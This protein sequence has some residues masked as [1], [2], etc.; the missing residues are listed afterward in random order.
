[1]N[2]INQ[3]TAGPVEVG[4]RDLYIHLFAPIPGRNRYA[5]AD[6]NIIDWGDSP[7]ISR[8][9]AI[10][11]ARLIAAAYSAFD[12]AGRELGIDATEL[13][14][15]LDL[16]ALIHA[17]R[18]VVGELDHD[19]LGAGTSARVLKLESLLARLK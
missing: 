18:E 13:A 1:M 19:T 10:A 12:K 11:N 3:Q 9:Q 14:G 4:E 8:D 5:I 15:K 2:P 6:A 17:A 16:V 7:I